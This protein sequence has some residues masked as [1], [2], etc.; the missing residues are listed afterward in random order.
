[1][2]NSM[3]ITW[4]SPQTRFLRDRY[5]EPVWHTGHLQTACVTFVEVDR[6]PKCLWNKTSEKP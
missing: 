6:M 1:M 4:L 5:T 2:N 3:Y